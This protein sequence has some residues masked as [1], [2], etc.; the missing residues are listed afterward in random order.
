MPWQTGHDGV[1]DLCMRKRWWLRPMCPDWSWKSREAWCRLSPLISCRYFLDAAELSIVR[2]RFSLSVFFHLCLHL[3]LSLSKWDWWRAEM[4]S[5][6]DF[7]RSMGRNLVSLEWP[8]TGM[9]IWCKVFVAWLLLHSSHTYHVRSNWSNS[10]AWRRTP[11]CIS[12]HHV[13]SPSRYNVQFEGFWF[14]AITIFFVDPAF[15]FL[16]V[17]QRILGQI[18][19][20]DKGY[21]PIR[22]WRRM[23]AS[24]RV[25]DVRN[26]LEEERSATV[27]DWVGTLHSPTGFYGLHGDS[28]RTLWTLWWVHD[29]ISYSLHRFLKQCFMDS[30]RTREDSAEY[31]PQSLC[32]LYEDC[33]L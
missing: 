2:S 22:E 33:L 14:I 15:Y 10:M 11:D 24:W 20:N 6:R 25:C 4:L 27:R 28:M 16:G 23:G 1:F 12:W 13:Y 31:S 8:C 26:I 18:I 3:L 5:G 17:K 21:S 29:C 7:Q 9:F 19:I 32:R 30:G